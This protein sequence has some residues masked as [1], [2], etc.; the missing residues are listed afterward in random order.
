MATFLL[1]VLLWIVISIVIELANAPEET[2]PLPTE[3]E[4]RVFD[5]GLPKINN[6]AEL[7]G[8]LN[9]QGY[10]GDEWVQAYVSWLEDRGFPA[11]YH[12]VLKENEQLNELFNDFDDAE[13]LII[14]GRGD[15][16]A[17]HE[18]AERSLA[19]DDPLEALAWYDRAIV[20]GSLYAMIRTSDLI[21]TLTDPALSEFITNPEW[22]QALSKL[23]AEDPPPRERALA[24]LLAAVNVGGYALMDDGQ[25]RRI[26][27]L[28]KQLD[29]AQ[30]ASACETAQNYVLEAASARRALG[31]AVF[32]TDGPPVAVTVSNAENIIACDVAI[33]PLVTMTACTQEN[34]VGPGP[35]LFTL[36]TCVE[37]L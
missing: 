13:L 12:W 22:Q 28:Q 14:A 8:R 16:A 27:T 6:R 25:A 36:W 2:L 9:E 23:R 3:S 17:M 10:A 21:T 35:E 34:F 19:A 26:T 31:N 1:G 20:S 4:V 5:M 18:L 33:A 24:W 11:S 30:L 32:T 7:I 37:P 29:P 15:L